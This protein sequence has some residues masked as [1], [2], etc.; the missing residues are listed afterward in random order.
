M[1]VSAVNAATWELIPM[2]LPKSLVV[3]STKV[4]SLVTVEWY[5]RT[6]AME[7]V[8]VT[9]VMKHAAVLSIVLVAKLVLAQTVRQK[10]R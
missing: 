7:E 8:I 9:H 1:I 2:L 5:L 3:R 6:V 10:L 4:L